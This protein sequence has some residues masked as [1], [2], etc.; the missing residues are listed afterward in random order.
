[1]LMK[2]IVLGVIAGFLSVSIGLGGGM[3]LLP[4]ITSVY[5]I[6]TIGF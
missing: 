2:R 4:V 5:G 6:G 3:V 1:M